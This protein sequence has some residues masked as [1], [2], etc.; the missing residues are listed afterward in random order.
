[1]GAKYNPTVLHRIWSIR[2][3]EKSNLNILLSIRSLLRMVMFSKSSKGFQRY[4]RFYL[5]EK[6][7]CKLYRTISRNGCQVQ[8][9]SITQNSVYSCPRE[10]Q[11][12]E[13][14]L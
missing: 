14:L 12:I 7:T 4:T 13:H 1:M 9:H 2:V 10:E 5:Q 3:Q 8:S 6:S 11:H